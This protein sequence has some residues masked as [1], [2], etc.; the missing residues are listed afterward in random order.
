MLTVF[1]RP[2][3]A[4][5]VAKRAEPSELKTS[6]SR[7]VISVWALDMLVPWVVT[8]FVRLVTAA[9]V[10][11]LAEPSELNTSPSKLVTS[12]AIEV[13]VPLRFTTVVSRVLNAEDVAKR[14]VPSP[15]NI[16][17]FIEFIDTWL[18]AI[19]GSAILTQLEPS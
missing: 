15:L 13:T 18:D 14:D 10:A 2:V 9:P 5:P 4:V 1:V 3:N 12:A 16:S 7:S 8:V 11:N 17:A 19:L 6:P